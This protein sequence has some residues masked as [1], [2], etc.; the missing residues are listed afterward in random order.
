LPYLAQRSYCA[1]SLVRDRGLLLRYHH[2]IQ[3]SHM[4]RYHEIGEIY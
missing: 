4:V 3:R 1:F 2:T